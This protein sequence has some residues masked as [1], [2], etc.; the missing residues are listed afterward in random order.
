M[1]VVTQVALYVASHY[2][3]SPNDLL[4][5]SDAPAHHLFVLLGMYVVCALKWVCHVCATGEDMR[6]VL[7]FVT[8]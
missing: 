2:K 1:Y 7:L 3:N 4:L 5:M 8:C 6:S